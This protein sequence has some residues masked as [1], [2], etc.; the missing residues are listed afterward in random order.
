MACKCG[1]GNARFIDIPGNKYSIP[2]TPYIVQ[3]T[4]YTIHSIHYI[5]RTSNTVPYHKYTL[6]Q[7]T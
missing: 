2:F 7:L 5:H 3:H 1:Q 6:Q 4:S